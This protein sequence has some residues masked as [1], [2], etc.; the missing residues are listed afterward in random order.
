MHS[1]A[2]QQPQ[3]PVPPAAQFPIPNNIPNFHIPPNKQRNSLPTAT[4]APNRMVIPVNQQDI[5][6]YMLLQTMKPTQVEEGRPPQVR[7]PS[8][9]PQLDRS[10][11]LLSRVSWIPDA[12]HDA[13]IRDKMVAQRK[14]AGRLNRIVGDVLLERMPEGLRAVTEEDVGKGKEVMPGQKKRKVQELAVTVDKALVFDRDVETVSL[15]EIAFANVSSCF[16]SPMS[17]LS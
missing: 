4:P 17:I 16:N 13:A 6:P 10:Q 15:H 3:Q 9:L 5:K 12:E 2:S 7:R 1:L 14:P 11:S 8:E